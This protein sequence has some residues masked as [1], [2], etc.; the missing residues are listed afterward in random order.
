MFAQLTEIGSTHVI[1]VQQLDGKVVETAHLNSGNLK[2]KSLDIVDYLA[3]H[4][5]CV[6][7]NQNERFFLCYASQ[8]FSNCVSKLLNLVSA[9]IDRDLVSYE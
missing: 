8:L 1:T 7:L 3:R 6:R 4:E 2:A 5:V 9:A